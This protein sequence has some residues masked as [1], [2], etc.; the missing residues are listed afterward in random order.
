[1]PRRTTIHR[2]LFARDVVNRYLAGQSIRQI[3]DATDASYGLIHALLTEND[4]RMRPDG[5]QRKPKF[6]PRKVV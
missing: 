2:E 3:A 6:V 1:M 4:V 5:G